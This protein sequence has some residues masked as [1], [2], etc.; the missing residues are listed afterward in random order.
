MMIRCGHFSNAALQVAAEIK[1][2]PQNSVNWKSV[3]YWKKYPS[4]T[5]SFTI[6]SKTVN[7]PITISM[8][9]Q[10]SSVLGSHLM[11]FMGS[12]G[13]L[14][15]RHFVPVVLHFDLLRFEDDAPRFIARYEA[16]VS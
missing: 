16:S 1:P 6:Q 13:N 5:D 9:V 12:T 10:S 11:R 3:R 14:N 4:H 2:H 7:A 8:R 15:R